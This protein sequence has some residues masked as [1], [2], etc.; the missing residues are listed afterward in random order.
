LPTGVFSSSH[1][2][3]KLTENEAQRYCVRISIGGKQFRLGTTYADVESARKMY[4]AARRVLVRVTNGRLALNEE[5]LDKELAHVTIRIYRTKSDNNP[6]SVL[7]K[8]YLRNWIS[9]QQPLTPR[10]RRRKKGP[11][12]PV[13]ADQ[14]IATSPGMPQP[15]FQLP[16]H[17]PQMPH[18]PP[19]PQMVPQHTIQQPV[20][21]HPHQTILAPQAT[22]TPQISS[23]SQQMVQTQQIQQ[24][25]QMQQMQ[26]IRLQQQQQQQQQHQHVNQQHATPQLAARQLTAQHHPGPQQMHHHQ[27]QQLQH[28]QMAPQVTQTVTIQSTHQNLAAVQ[29]PTQT[30]HQV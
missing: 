15:N 1:H 24:M 26:Q 7:M 25:Q 21:Q 2:G 16:H 17:L 29:K 27:L 20:L 30:S 10:R 13:G 23:I 11:T 6:T 28:H 8:D 22:G 14:P 5:R 12:R 3:I 4:L 9:T 18:M 19:M